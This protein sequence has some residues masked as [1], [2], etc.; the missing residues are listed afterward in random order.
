MK[1]GLLVSLSVVALGWLAG[2]G[3]GINSISGGGGTQPNALSGQYAFLL[4]GFDSSGNPM[5]MAGSFKADGFGHITAGE[6]DVNDNGTAATSSS[7]SGTYSF[8]NTGTGNNTTLGTVSLSTTV[9][10]VATHALG[11]AFSLQASGAFGQIMSLDQNGFIAAGTM[12]LQSSSA[13]TLAGLAGDFVASLDGRT[14]SSP[15][16]ALGSFTLA[17]S[18]ATSNDTFDRSIAGVGTAATTGASAAVLF[19]PAGPDANGRGTFTLTLNDGLATT[20]TQNFAYYAITAKRIVAVETDSSGS[21]TADFASQTIP[22]TPTTTGSV[23]GM[24]GLDTAVSD[25]ISA[26]GQLQMTGVGATAGTL[27]WDANDAVDGSG[28]VFTANSSTLDAVAY[29]PTTG[30]GTVTISGGNTHGIGDTLVFYLS[31]AGTGFILD[32]TASANNRAM[33]GPL[34]A[35]ATGSFSAATDL[36]GLGIFRS[37]GSSVNDAFALVGLFGPS[38]GTTPYT[39][40]FDVRQ[41]GSADALDQTTGVTVGSIAGTVGRG[42]FTFAGSSTTNA[43]YIVGPNQFV[44][45]DITQSDGASPVF[46]VN[47]D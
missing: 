30:R 45:I 37:R 4:A 31:G 47:P 19:A 27:N 15:T 11:F 14:S 29:D 20:V 24:A 25:E 22:A 6:V 46:F 12:Q 23:F 32:A 5:G 33:A 40:L 39:A 13:F 36:S 44:F 2:C 41:P 16:S 43:F 10:T 34:T 1:R 17:S 28:S 7:V 26:V 35:Q 42:T 38:T 9:G 8:D 3:G 18:G 21:M